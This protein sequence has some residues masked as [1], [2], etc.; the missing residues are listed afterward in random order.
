MRYI[1]A[2]EAALGKKARLELLPMQQGDMAATEADTRALEEQTGFR[3]GTSVEEG[4][5]RFV[6]WYRDYYR[7]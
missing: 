7:S 6:S 1:R 3:P 4:I 2:L 5:G